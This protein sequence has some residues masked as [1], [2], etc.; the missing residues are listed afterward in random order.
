MAIDYEI[1]KPNEQVKRWKVVKKLGG[2]GF[3][4]VYKVL[5][6]DGKELAMK[7]EPTAGSK[8]VLRSELAIF[9]RIQGKPHAPKLFGSGRMEAYTFITL[10]LLSKNLSEL[11]RDS[12][13]Q[14]FSFGTA[15]RLGRQALESLQILHN[16]GIIHRDVKPSNF[17]M[18]VCSATK[19]TVFVFDFGLSR[20]ILDQNGALRQPRD[21]SGFRGTVRYASLAAHESR[22]MG[23][24]DDL[25]SLFYMI[26]EMA[27]GILP[28]RRIRAKEEV[29]RWKQ[30]AKPEVL[31]ETLPKSL[32]QIGR[33]LMTL[34]YYDRPEYEIIDRL[35][36]DA[37]QEKNAPMDGLFDWEEDYKTV[38]EEERTRRTGRDRQQPTH[39]ETKA[40]AEGEPTPEDE[41]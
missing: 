37:L 41:H 39:F 19:K 1:L 35:L 10:Q 36:L 27:R 34:T 15:F 22:E 38:K 8:H 4:Q 26:I 11:R 7:V 24:H 30:R 17:A 21:W 18:G 2:G 6:R 23:R 12:P 13:G 20:Q 28:W 33:H 31:C 9:K 5:D 14:R 25:W 40:E 3:G 32:A 29:G 16:T